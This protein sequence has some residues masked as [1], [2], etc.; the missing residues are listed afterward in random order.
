[1]KKVHL[2]FCLILISS[3]CL[4]A[5][6]GESQALA[7]TDDAEINAEENGL[8]EIRPEIEDPV[9]T[10]GLGFSYIEMDIRTSS[11]M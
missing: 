2:L 5:Q 3:F 9:G 7:E 1:M 10:T 6:E 8:E 4:F 11:L